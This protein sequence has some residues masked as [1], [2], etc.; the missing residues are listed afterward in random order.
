MN[1][2]YRYHLVVMAEPVGA[3][4]LGVLLFGQQL[5]V[6]AIVGAVGILISVLLT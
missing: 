5:S 2:D 3:Y 6:W 4:A 1:K